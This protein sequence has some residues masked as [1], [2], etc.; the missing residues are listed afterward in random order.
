MKKFATIFLA[1]AVAAPA[2]ATNG[3]FL[4]GQGTANK[5]LAGAGTALAQDALDADTNPAAGAFLP[6]G[7]SVSLALF[8]PDRSYTVTG[9]PSGYPQTFGLTPGTVTSK[10]KY[11]PMPGFGI[12]VKLD[13]VS[14]VTVNFTAHGGM[15]TDYRTATFY[16]ANHTGVDLGQAFLTATYSRK[17]TPNQSLGVTAVLAGQRFKAQ[18]LE[19][20]AAFSSDPDCLTGR[21][22]DTSRGVG[23]KFGYLAKVTPNLSFGASYNPRIHMSKFKSYCGLFAQDGRFDIPTSYNAGVAVKPA[24]DLTLTA[25]Y[26]RIDYNNVKAVG[27]PL[28]PN[29]MASPLGAATG[30]GF[31]WKNVNVY[32]V[33]AQF[34]ANEELTLRAGYSQADQPIPSSEVLFNILA[35]GVVERHITA[36][37]SK[38]LR[39]APGRFNFA[40][41]YAPNKTVRGANP[42]EA[43]GQQSIALK[44]HEWEVEFGYSLGF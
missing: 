6:W 28:F 39:N 38:S 3:Y 25:D 31:G 44:M 13:E 37:F 5:A 9:N 20:F 22:Y 36:G 30:A 43:P 19:Q 26:Q 11:F 27:N 24:E 16:G 12:N 34:K 29:L 33:G 23:A 42:L 35:P 21:G 32:K 8:S 1:L 15:N 40:A 41:M 7:Y 2:L 17:I 14:A 10:S 18:G 4:H